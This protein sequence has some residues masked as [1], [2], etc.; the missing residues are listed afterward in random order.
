MRTTA[1]FPAARAAFSEAG[2]LT[3]AAW[4]RL[5]DRMEGSDRAA[6]LR[7]K[8]GDRDAFREIVEAQSR[9]VFALAFRMTGN[10][11]DAEDVVQETFLKAYRSIASFQG[12]SEVS[13]WLHR[14]AANCAV[15]L[16]RRRKGAGE[17]APAPAVVFEPDALADARS[18]PEASAW[19][20]E[21]GRRV[22]ASLSRLS[23]MERIAF[24]LRHYE[25]RSIA[26][27]ARVLGIRSGATK[28]CVFRAV[29]KL[30]EDLEPLR[31]AAR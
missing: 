11:Q 2:W 25:G 15:D 20:S 13:T 3:S 28:N 14:I 5:M 17:T 22:S 30:R 21:I 31:S 9:N 12:A 23:P 24:T 19:G 16:L 18:G 1:A 29:A 26:E 10:E 6:A 27:I 8:A 7:V 4:L